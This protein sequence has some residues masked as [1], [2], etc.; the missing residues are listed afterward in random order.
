[1]PCES[2]FLPPVETLKTQPH[3][4]LVVAR[5]GEPV[6]YGKEDAGLTPQGH[7]QVVTTTNQILESINWDSV[8]KLNMGFYHTGRP[9]TVQSA[10]LGYSS[11]LA[12][13]EEHKLQEKVSLK[14]WS[15]LGVKDRPSGKQEGLGILQTKVL[16][17]LH[18]EFGIDIQNAYTEYMNSQEDELAK[19]R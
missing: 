12:F 13:L 2:P 6:E 8:H 1:M 3:L 11:A 9:R 10:F 7:E 19:G 4:F 16:S 18:K 14:P 17:Q 5:H 15:N